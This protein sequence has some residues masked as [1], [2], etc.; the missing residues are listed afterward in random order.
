MPPVKQSAPVFNININPFSGEQG[1][2]EFFSE[3][4]NDLIK[5]NKW[6]NEHAVIFLK[7]KL[8]GAA[9]KYY[10]ESPKLKNA[11]TVKEIFDDFKIF[12]SSPSLASAIHELNSLHMLPAESVKNL[13]HRLNVLTRKVYPN[14][15]NESDL[16]NIKFVKFLQIIP[17]DIRLKILQDG[18]T[19]YTP[20][21]EK[22]QL[23][24]EHSIQNE[25]LNNITFPSISSNFSEQLKT[26]QDQINSITQSSVQ[27]N[28]QNKTQ[29]QLSDRDNS[30]YK[31]NP[32]NSFHPT[33]KFRSV[34]QQNNFRSFNY[35]NKS[36]SRK[37]CKFCKMRN[38]N[39]DTCFKLLRNK[40]QQTSFRNFGQI[41]QKSKNRSNHGNNTFSQ[42]NSPNLM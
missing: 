34:G 40:S 42:A 10:L 1:T 4:I 41:P 25:V 11:Q 27:S 30:H 3:Q 31:N 6:S 38:H 14:I 7:S 13:A 32:Y 22:A 28:C 21:V 39:I 19:Q 9:L 2:L 8:S 26:L 24:Q 29:V 37:F 12:F 20:A 16:E 33:R 36:F 5:I 35:N 15:N 23:F 18:I 17:S